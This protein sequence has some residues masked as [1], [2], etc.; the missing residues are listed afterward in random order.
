MPPQPPSVLGSRAGV[1][2]LTFALVAGGVSRAADVQSPLADYLVTSWVDRDGVPIGTVYAVA[3]DKSGYLWLGTESGLVRFDGFRFVSAAEL[4]TGEFPR[5]GAVSVF[6]T[7]DGALL[8]GFA[9]GEAVKIRDLRVQQGELPD[10]PISRIDALA[11]DMSGTI[12]AVAG[13]RA[14]RYRDHQ[15]VETAIDASRVRVL[16][17]YVGRSGRLYLT[18][19]QGVYR[20]TADGT[21]F[22]RLSRDFA[23]AVSEGSD[24]NVW[25]THPVYGFVRAG[26]STYD[27]TR[28]GNGYRAIHDSEGNLWIATIGKGL[29]RAKSSTRGG[30]GALQVEPAPALPGDSAQALFEDR[31]RNVWVGTPAGLLRLTRKPLIPVAYAGPILAIEATANGTGVWAGT[32][33]DGLVKFSRSGERW[34]RTVHSAPEVVVYSLHHDHA[35]TLWVVTNRGLGRVEHDRVVLVVRTPTWTTGTWLTSDR[36][37]RLWMGDR[38][39]LFSYE[40][41]RLEEARFP[42]MTR[43]VQLGA[44]DRQDRLWVAFVDGAVGVVDA[45]GTFRQVL[46]SSSGPRAVR[47]LFED[48]TGAMWIGA[49]DGLYRYSGKLSSVQLSPESSRNQV[50]AI[51]E[52]DDGFLWI[53]TDLGVLRI[54]PKELPKAADPAHLMRYRFFDGNDGL[55]GASVEFLRAAKG[56]DSTVWFARGGTLTTLDPNAVEFSDGL[57]SASVRIESVATERGLVDVS[58][59][60]SLSAGTRRLD[61]TFSVLRLSPTPRLRFRHRLEGFDRDWRDAGTR[62]SASYTN[63][64]PGSYRLVVEAYS[65]QGPFG[66]PAT[67]SFGLPPTIFETP[68]FRLL[69]LML[70]AASVVMAWWL[71]TRIVRRQFAAVL[72]ERARVSR[73]IHDTLL[74]GVLGISLQLDHLEHAHPVEEADHRRRIGRLRL[75]LEAYIRDARQSI[76]DLRSPVLEHRSFEEALHELAARLTSDTAMRCS[77]KVKGKPRECPPRV[78]NELLRIAHEAIVNAVRHSGGTWV[79][80]ELRFDE[81]SIV[82]RVS[83]DGRGFS[84]EGAS[85]SEPKR[86]GLLSMKER[87]KTFGGELTIVT[88]AQRGTDIEAVFPM[89][90]TA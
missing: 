51:V 22:E 65:T 85:L 17:A 70:V 60:P 88:S 32:R 42:W 11:E 7:R 87:A 3:Q 50:W 12:W 79:Q 45:A 61:V 1:L 33:S 30:T 56:F 10:Q 34:H 8:V 49:S 64:P 27:H 20:Q 76:L 43:P 62:T 82:L 68:A 54:H 19:G 25:A 69:L 28:L 63:L 40:K 21:S 23:Y 75:Q 46:N 67:W 81:S 6:V 4:V 38:R 74:Q 13:G 66:Q 77:V 26:K 90:A 71:R 86:F 35:G 57:P 73:E 9:S 31:Q 53:N 2:A 83:D 78:E 18:S 84:L 47:S 37:G 14:H 15:W 41:E 36:T 58:A 59:E 89:R 72:E 52:D 24:G 48:H 55:A 5:A 80:T 29:W 39:R 44:I 16:N